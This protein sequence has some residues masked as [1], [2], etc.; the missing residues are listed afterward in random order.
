VGQRITKRSVDAAKPSKTEYFLWDGEL[1]GFGL[2]VRPSGVK[3]Y[4]VKYRVGPGRRAPVRRITLGKHGK[5]TPDTAREAAR[6][7]LADVVHGADP[8]G[9]RAHRRREMTIGDLAERYVAEHIKLHNKPTTAVEFERLV[10]S[11]IIPA[12]GTSRVGDLTR[13]DVKMWHTRMRLAPYAA[14]RALAVLRKM[15]SLAV[16][17]WELRDDNPAIGV[18]MF[19]ETR[20]ERFATDDDLARMGRWLAKNESSRTVHPGFALTVRLLALTGMRLGEVLTLEWSMVD[21]QVGV[22]R[23]LDAKAGARDVALG[24]AAVALLV[25]LAAQ[26]GRGRFVVPGDDPSRPFARSTFR[27]GWQHLLAGTGL[28]DVRPHDLRHTTGTFAAQAGANAFL[29]RDLLGHK[30]L[31]MTGR[32][33]ERA[34]D[35][36]R[37]LADQVSN[38]VAAAMDGQEAK[39]LPFEKGDVEDQSVRR[40]G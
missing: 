23:L 11:R 34:A 2:R 29:V 28:A 25:S 27:T 30:T 20:R 35:P 38:R 33:V 21:L 17:D 26:Q 15:F 24:A 18:K 40:A 6:T 37:A 8:A 3:S 7:I 4:V 22:I 32:Y 10:R 14:N 1:I 9:D 16:N 31:A 13:A 39:V 36:M 5:L 19:R 12:F